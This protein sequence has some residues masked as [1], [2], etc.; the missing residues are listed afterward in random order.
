M[1]RS[2]L[3][4]SLRG[5]WAADAAVSAPSPPRAPSNDGLPALSQ[6]MQGMQQAVHKAAFVCCTYHCGLRGHNGRPCWTF[7]N[8]TSASVRTST[9]PKAVSTQRRVSARARIDLASAKDGIWT[10]DATDIHGLCIF[11]GHDAN[12]RGFNDRFSLIRAYLDTAP[13]DD[14]EVESFA[15]CDPCAECNN[16]RCLV[17][18]RRKDDVPHRHRRSCKCV[19]IDTA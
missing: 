7:Q 17:L 11:C 2:P 3:P 18:S 1:A 6:G 10:D 4:G 12:G 15:A 13:G 16:N 5:C 9:M 8:W 14:V 19:T